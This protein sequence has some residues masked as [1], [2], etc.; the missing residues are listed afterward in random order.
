MAIQMHSTSL[1]LLCPTTVSNVLM[2][3]INPLDHRDAS[4]PPSPSPPP[5]QPSLALTVH[6][7]DR[8]RPELVVTHPLVRVCLVSCENGELVKKPRP[9]RRVTSYYEDGVDC[10]LPVLTQP[11]RNKGQR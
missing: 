9:D 11:W 5:P 3:I 7:T 2:V 4:L 6:K 10:I 1:L 8:L